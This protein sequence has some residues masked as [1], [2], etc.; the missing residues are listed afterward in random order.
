MGEEGST[1]VQLGEAVVAS[2]NIF[3]QPCQISFYPSPKLWPTLAY[4][5]WSISIR[6]PSGL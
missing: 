3:P 4:A 2:T 5:G 1:R 6:V